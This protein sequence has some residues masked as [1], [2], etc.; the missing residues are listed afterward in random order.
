MASPIQIVLNHKDYEQARDAGGGGPKKDFYANRDQEFQAHK[1]KLIGQLTAISKAISAQSQGDVGYIKV[2]LRRDAWAKS[3]RPLTALFKPQRISMVG[4][5]DLGE[6]Y[7]EARPRILDGLAAEIATAEDETRLKF[8]KNKKKDVPNPS[9]IRSETG[10]I[11]K[12]EIYGPRDRRSFSLEEAVGWL[13]SPMT[14][15]AYQIELFDVPPPHNEW[16]AFDAGRQK[17]YRSFVEGLSSA[18]AGLA[19]QRV[20]IREKAQPLI[21][22]RVGRSTQAPTLLLDA[23]PTSERKRELAPFDPALDRHRRLLAFL[24]HHPLVR[25]IDLPAI[26]V[27]TIDGER[28][29]AKS[30]ADRGRDRPGNIE[31]PIRNS[32][33]QYP[34]VGIVDGGISPHLSDWVIDRWDVIDA[35]DADLE[36]ATFIGGLAVAGGALNTSNICKEPDGAE[37]IDIAVYPTED[38]PGAFS[39]Y[40]PR[41]VTQ[42]F[43]EVEYAI[44]DAKARHGVRVF[45]LSLNVQHPAAPDRYSLF[46]ARLD[47]IAEAHDAIIFVPTGNTLQQDARAEWPTDDTN[48][49]VALAS[50][51]NNSMLMPAESVRN[52]SVAALNPPDLST[53]I[54]NAPAR[55]S[56]RGP[57]LRTGIKPDVAHI[58]GSG[59]PQSPLGHGLFS[60]KPDGSIYDSC[61]TSYAAPI[62]AKTAAVLEHSIEGTVSRETLIGLLLH[63]AEMPQLLKSKALQGVARDLVGFGVP[64]S[65]QEILEASDRCHQARVCI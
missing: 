3:H 65:A 48:A 15:S 50:A 6:I 10:A 14:G 7:F 56:R 1:A 63:H 53:C 57:G 26:V 23:P 40:Y 51:R 62:V 13:T 47:Q 64:P 43:D 61:G 25:H 8:D 20:F 4:G 32:A 21:A 27:R 60:F 37:L 38:D 42:F 19:V 34:R 5:G 29:S 44:G 28:V 11:D 39:S 52:V 16:D 49:L 35:A 18:G 54:P 31:L 58:G 36:H 2:I 17:L 33:R 12:I 45:N 24:D 22:V 9:V 30:A 46:A 41:G 59:S 55:Y